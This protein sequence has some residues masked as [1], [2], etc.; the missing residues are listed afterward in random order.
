MR[1]MTLS[2]I[3]ALFKENLQSVNL[4]PLSSDFKSESVYNG[5]RH[6]PN[7]P[8]IGQIEVGTE[9]HH[10]KIN[11]T[12][13]TTLPFSQ[14]DGLF[15]LTN[16]LREKFEGVTEK[17]IPLGITIY[18]NATE[19]MDDRFE[20]YYVYSK[21]GKDTT[22]KFNGNG[23][24]FYGFW[25]TSIKYCEL[26]KISGTNPVSLWIIEDGKKLFESP[27][28]SDK[29]IIYDKNNRKAP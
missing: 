13:T 21:A 1:S 6:G 15:Y 4:K 8:V 7:L 22:V 20:G 29:P 18:G 11:G 19:G 5:M 10:D 16:T 25:G 14:K 27:K 9:V 3:E 17:E 23:N 12:A 24:G 26:H 2:F 28:F